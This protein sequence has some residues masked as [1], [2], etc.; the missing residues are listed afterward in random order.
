M[1]DPLTPNYKPGVGRLVTS[2][3][4]FQ[5][6][7]DGY[8]FRH[9]ANAITLLPN[10]T[11][12]GY[13]QGTVQE[14]IA[15]LAT[16]VS[17]PDIIVN[18]ATLFTKGIVQLSGDIGGTSG[19]PRVLKIQSFPISTQTP[20]N[21]QV[22][23]WNGSNWIPNTSVSNFTA[24]NDLFGDNTTQTVIGIQGKSIA[25][26]N[27]TDAQVLTWVSLNNRWEP[28]TLTPSGTGFT[29]ITSGVF[30]SNATSNIR[31]AGGKFQTDENIQYKNGSITGDLVWQPTS[32][33]KTIT[34]PDTTDTLIGQA[35]NDTL[36]NKTIN[37]SNN[38]L[39][40]TSQAAG[41]LLKNNGTSFIRFAKG[42]AL[43]VLRVNSSGTDLEWAASSSGATSS[44]ATN[45]VQLSDGSGGFLANGTL[46]LNSG[47]SLKMN[48]TNS[49]IECLVPLAGQSTGPNAF[50]LQVVTVDATTVSGSYTPTGV[51]AAAPVWNITNSSFNNYVNMPAQ[52]GAI[53]YVMNTSAD[54]VK[55]RAI[56]DVGASADVTTG[57][58]AIVLHNGTR[59][60]TFISI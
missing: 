21:G 25:N 44:G 56:G 53:Y 2:R 54:T 24:S 28:S 33:N 42:S 59:Y 46:G 23:T 8:S 18:D 14:A 1:S 16:V 20:T 27:P 55:F 41:D 7:I 3:F 39:T 32:I 22:L 58:K 12:D 11:V 4:D 49:A 52:T 31:Y 47:G 10:V 5:N 60:I 50:C 37:T 34:L 35:T 26:V 40:A 29:T 57:Q 38:S 36:T 45:S 19:S 43:Q 6:H 17:P 51:E 30:D 15:K 13:V 9:D 48:I